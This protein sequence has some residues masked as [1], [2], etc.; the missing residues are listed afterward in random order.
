VPRPQVVA[1][2][3]GSSSV[4]ALIR[5][6]EA[7]ATTTQL[8]QQYGVSATA[9]K[10]LLHCRDVV[11]RR[12]V[13]LQPLEVDEAV[14]FYESGWQLREI[15]QKFDASQENVRRRLLERGVTMRSGHGSTVAGGVRW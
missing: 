11:V 2:R 3:L 7:G 1:R 5:S 10:D 12:R 8:A 14:R 4:A 15:A 6:Y 13:G 9:V